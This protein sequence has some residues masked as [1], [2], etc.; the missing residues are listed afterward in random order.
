MHRLKSHI[1]RNNHVELVTATNDDGRREVGV[2]LEH[3]L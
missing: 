2:A 3:L 1:T